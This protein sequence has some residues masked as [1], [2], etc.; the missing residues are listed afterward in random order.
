MPLTGL[1]DHGLGNADAC[2]S[3]P[4]RTIRSSRRPG[5]SVPRAR[6]KA[7]ACAP[8]GASADRNRLRP[9]PGR[10]VYIEVTE[11]DPGELGHEAT[12]AENDLTAQM[13]HYRRCMPP[14][15]PVGCGILYPLVL[16][17]VR[18]A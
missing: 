16:D 11:G 10:R 14:P 6:R 7:A 18:A 5:S 1:Y 2:A 12:A 15:A 4:G 17:S 3:G 8:R 9:A 13:R